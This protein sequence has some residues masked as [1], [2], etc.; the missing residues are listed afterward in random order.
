[1]TTIMAKA[2]VEMQYKQGYTGL[3]SVFMGNK[4]NV[5]TENGIIK[6]ALLFRNNSGHF[7]VDRDGTQAVYSICYWLGKDTFI[8]FY[9][10]GMVSI[11]Y[12]GLF[13]SQ[14]VNSDKELLNLVSEMKQYLSVN[15]PVPFKNDEEEDYDMF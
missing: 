14:W 12:D 13:Q 9:R 2:W 1:M 8:S 5:I 11:S 3:P 7:F 4:D 10:D 6:T 15:P